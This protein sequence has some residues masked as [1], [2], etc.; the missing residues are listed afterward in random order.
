M[1]HVQAGDF[2]DASH[3]IE[4]MLVEK[5]EP[6]LSLKD[7]HLQLALAAF[8]AMELEDA[9]DHLEHFVDLATGD[10]KARGE[11]AIDLLEQGNIHDAEHEVEE[12]LE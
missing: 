4:E 5:A 9:R 7:L 12:L 11:E 10:E 6:E 8:E 3:I 2:H 1:E